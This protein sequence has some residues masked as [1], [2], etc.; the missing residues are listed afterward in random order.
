[1]VWG[2][3]R[4]GWIESGGLLWRAEA[5]WGWSGLKWM[6]RACASLASLDG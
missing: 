1:M 5:R 4:S 3:G 2:V 6:P